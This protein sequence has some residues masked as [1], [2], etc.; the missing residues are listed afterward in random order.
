MVHCQTG[1]RR[2]CHQRNDIGTFGQ[3]DRIILPI[4]STLKIEASLVSIYPSILLLNRL[5]ASSVTGS[6]RLTRFAVGITEQHRTVPPRHR[7]RFP[8]THSSINGFKRSYSASTLWTRN[9]MMTVFYCWLLLRNQYRTVAPSANGR[10]PGCTMSKQV[11][12]RQARGVLP[13]NPKTFS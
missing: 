7:G 5:I 3:N 9:S 10:L 4:V 6:K 11:R 2:G 13:K 8:F 12:Q 1:I